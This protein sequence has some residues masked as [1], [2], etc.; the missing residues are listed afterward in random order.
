MAA[1]A[2]VHVSV[3]PGLMAQHALQLDDD[4]GDELIGRD[5]DWPPIRRFE[6]PVNQ[7]KGAAL[8]RGFAEARGDV[9]VV[10]D[11]DAKEE[12]RKLFFENIKQKVTATRIAIVFYCVF[13]DLGKEIMKKQWLY[14]KF[15]I[16]FISASSHPG[17]KND[18]NFE[19]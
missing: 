15:S 9:V 7:G 16:Y 18:K 17:Q 10:Q 4:P 6:Q 8:R 14:Y 2:R 19:V 13:F 5:R 12:L 1:S 11:A 3:L